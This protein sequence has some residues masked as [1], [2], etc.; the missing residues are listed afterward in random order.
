MA[1][2]GEK[3]ENSDP[4]TTSSAAAGDKKPDHHH[5]NNEK[6][7]TIPSSRSSSESSWGEEPPP[8]T[9]ASVAVT[10]PPPATDAYRI[11]SEVFSRTKSSPTDWSV[12]SNESL[13]SIN[14]GN[15]SFT[16]EHALLF[17][18]SGEFGYGP[19]QSMGGLS[20][21]INGPSISTGISPTKSS[22]SNAGSPTKSSTS[23]AGS[24]IKPIETAAPTS[25]NGITASVGDTE[26]GGGSTREVIKEKNTSGGNHRDAG[27]VESA[28]TQVEKEPS[29][30]KSSSVR[31]SSTDSVKSFAFPILTGD[32]QHRPTKSQSQPST[33]RSEKKDKSSELAAATPRSSTNNKGNENN[34]TNSDSKLFSCLPCCSSPRTSP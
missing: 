21:M 27:T 30:E 34:G 13:F 32:G 4:S 29:F 3:P 11:P 19:S 24:P 16:K 25:S 18:K 28:P 26:S 8:E 5:I 2:G 14:T 31:R 6:M 10:Q 9:I 33:A 1:T 17:A 23:N 7:A 12:A 15:M 22:T 20:P